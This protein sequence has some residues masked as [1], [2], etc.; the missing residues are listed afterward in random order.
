MRRVNQSDWRGSRPSMRKS[1][2]ELLAFHTGLLAIDYYRFPPPPYVGN[3]WHLD[4]VEPPRNLQIGSAIVDDERYPAK[5]VVV[6]ASSEVSAQRA[7]DLIHAARLVLDGS[8][9]ASHLYPG[10]HAPIYPVSTDGV[11]TLKQRELGLRN[12]TRL[13]TSNIPL[14]CMVATRASARLEYIYALAKIRLSL[15]TYSLP[16]IALDPSQGKNLPK[17]PLPEDHVRMAFAIVTPWSCVEELGFE[18]HASPKKPSKLPDGSWNPAVRKDLESRLQKGHI[19]LKEPIDWNL[20][21]PRTRI[22]KKRM[23]SIIQKAPWAR[24]QVRDGEMEVIDAIHYLS[25]LRSW[26][27]AHRTDK[28]MVRVLSVYDTANAQFVARRLFLEK[29]GFWKYLGVEWEES[30]G[31]V[32][33]FETPVR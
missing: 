17:S 10:E 21:G 2:I 4:L 13:M 5:E 18:I 26:V 11:S 9:Y 30:A 6:R 15:E 20:R 19:N 27:A 7:A 14:A 22:E 33:R 28:R 31:D 29:M 8:N 1:S 25:F 24:Y 3:G 23:P 12:R 32:V 16:I